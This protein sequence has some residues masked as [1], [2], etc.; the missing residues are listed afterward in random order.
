M[1]DNSNL[2]EILEKMKKSF[3]FSA[4]IVTFSLFYSCSKSSSTNTTPVLSLSTTAVTGIT[5][6]TALSGGS[7]TYDGTDPISAKGICWNTTTNPTTSA[8]KTVDGTGTAQFVS[9]LTGL[10]MGK[11]YFARAYATISSGT[12]YGNE[13]TFTTLVR[14]LPNEVFIQGFAF[15]PQTLTVPVNTTVKWTNKDGTTHTVTSNSGAFDSGS[16]TDGSSYSFQFNT[17]GTYPYHCSI[18]P[19]M[20]AS[21]IVQ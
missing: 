9:H 15:S 13:V 12:T 1:F 4:L 7:I 11:I 21:I 5:D 2:F 8:S 18:H 14:Q 6:T 17:A 10:T 19:S 20:T 3:L 16:L